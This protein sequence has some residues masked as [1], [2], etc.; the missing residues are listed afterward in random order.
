MSSGDSETHG[1]TIKS[2]ETALR[3]LEELRD[4]DCTGVTELAESLDISKG[5]VHHHINT[6]ARQNYLEREDGTYR[7]GLGMLTFGGAART[8]ER[9]FAL[10]RDDVDRLAEETGELVTLVAEWDGNGVTLYQSAGA[11]VD[12]VTSHV[13]EVQELHCTAAGKAFLAKL[14][15]ERLDDILDVNELTRYTEN[16]ITDPDQLAAELERTRSQ[17]IAFDDEEYRDGKRCVASAV[18]DNSGELLGAIS[19]S[20]PVERVGDDRFRSEIPHQ[21]RNTVGVVEI[22]TTY[23][24]WTDQFSH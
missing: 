19:V 22:N 6:L 16:T 18:C 23:S 12:E 15:D 14:P 8:R 3:I 11:N 2:V 24:Q 21:I 4:S 9:I 1:K 7:L 13:G 10:A 5:T 20:G 17:G